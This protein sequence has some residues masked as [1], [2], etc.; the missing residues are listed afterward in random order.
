MITLGT[1]FAFDQ[2]SLE[3]TPTNVSK[4]KKILLKRGIYDKLFGSENVDLDEFTNEVPAWDKDTFISAK[5]DGTLFGGNVNFSVET[6]DEIKLKRREKGTYVWVTLMSLPITKEED[7]AFIYYDNLG[8]AKVTYEYA[9]VPVYQ[10]AEGFMTLAEVYSDF[11]GIYI[12]GNDK[13]YFGFLNLSFPKPTRKKES[14]VVTTLDNQYPY[15]INNSKTNYNTDSCSAT[16]VDTDEDSEWGWDFE[17]GWKYREEFK[18]W[19]YNGK[20]KILKY[21]TGRTWLI[22]VSGEIT[23]N[24]NGVEE[25]TVTSFTWYEIG[26]YKNPQHLYNQGLVKEVQ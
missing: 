6:T 16:W 4:I 3:P 18:N 13:A 14:S 17:D 19:L 22:G 24:I 1:S 12:V 2:Y 8:S 25:N 15:I 20:A 10:G 23:D 21:Y 26:N 5:F 7:F 11:D 9:I